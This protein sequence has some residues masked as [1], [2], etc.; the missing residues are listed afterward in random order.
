VAPQAV[1]PRSRTLSYQKQNRD[2]N[3]DRRVRSGMPYATLQ[4]PKPELSANATMILGRSPPA[5]IQTTTSSSARVRKPPPGGRTCSCRAG[6]NVIPT[7]VAVA[8]EENVMGFMG[9]DLL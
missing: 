1:L 4:S 6:L 8:A 2:I 7:G 9:S 5:P 3:I